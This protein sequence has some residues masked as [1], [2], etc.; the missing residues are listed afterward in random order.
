MDII[1]K[2]F[3]C[4]CSVILVHD[5]AA[6]AV[7]PVQAEGNGEKKKH[8]TK[9]LNVGNL[10]YY[11]HSDSQNFQLLLLHQKETLKNHFQF[12]SSY[13]FQHSPLCD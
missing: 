4:T 13:F 11:S 7:S 12:L 2:N 5:K 3:T 1:K 8:Q 6:H 9:S 10:L